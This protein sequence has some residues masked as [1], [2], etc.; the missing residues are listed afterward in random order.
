MKKFLSFLS[1]ILSI[2]TALAGLWPIGLYI[3]QAFESIGE[4]DKSLLFWGMPIL[5]IGLSIL[6][7]GIVFSVISIKSLRSNTAYRW[8]MIMLVAWVIVVPLLV[9][10]SLRSDELGRQRSAEIK[11]QDTSLASANKI[12][13]VAILSNDST[14]FNLCLTTSGGFEGDYKLTIAVSSDPITLLEIT[15]DRQLGANAV[16]TDTRIDYND[17]FAR[18]GRDLQNS[19]AHVCINNTLADTVLKI[20]TELIPIRAADT[21]IPNNKLITA[22]SSQQIQIILETENRNNEIIVRKF[23]QW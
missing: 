20:K 2:V 12:S 23:T 14:G 1:I 6:A 11:A 22:T 21:S 3:Y 4:A 5:F 19:T 15:E 16:T 10:G 7:A 17:L 8:A 13:N 9:M 18:C